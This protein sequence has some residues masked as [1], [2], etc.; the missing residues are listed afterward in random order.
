MSQGLYIR[1]LDRMELL[2]SNQSVGDALQKSKKARILVALLV[3]RKGEPVPH[4]E[5]CEMLW[6]KESM[7]D[8]N[9]ALKVLICRTR[10]MLAA[11]DPALRNCILAMPGAY[12]WNMATTAQ[13]DV[14]EIET[15]CNELLEND[16]MDE[17]QVKKLERMLSLYSQK[18]LPELAQV[19]WVAEYTHRLQ[20]QCTSVIIHSLDQLK[21]AG[22]W[23][24][25]VKICRMSQ[26]VMPQEPRWNEE[27]M[28]AFMMLNRRSDAMT[29]YEQAANS[30][31]TRAWGEPST[32]ITKLYAQILEADGAL[33]RDTENVAQE[34]LTFDEEDGAL[35]CD[36]IVFKH[37]YRLQQRSLERLGQTTFLVLFKVSGVTDRTIQVLALEEAMQ[38]LGRLLQHNLRRG[39]TIAR[40]TPS[41]YVV[42]LQGSAHEAVKG[43][44]DRVR[45]NF[46]GEMGTVAISLDYHYK[47]LSADDGKTKIKVL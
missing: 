39:D 38:R 35:F 37:V 40:Y 3:L 36:Y 23:E 17:A 1:L 25:I 24:R 27:M 11:V 41:Q 5:L 18:L 47:P 31:R 20:R 44:L 14:F 10:A 42:L 16:A 30:E 4:A 29:Q 33:T 21:E 32:E 46:Y 26:D 7:Q 13:V 43:V 22:E 2:L 12:A 28:R 6:E 19:E 8:L 15:I 45:L 9:N 34:L